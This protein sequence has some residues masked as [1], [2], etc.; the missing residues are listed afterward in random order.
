MKN[1]DDGE[2]TEGACGPSPALSLDIGAG[3]AAHL[4]IVMD[5]CGPNLQIAKKVMGFGLPITWSILPNQQYSKQIAQL[6][7]ESGVPFL[8]H[9]PMQAGVDPDGKAGAAGLYDI[10]VGMSDEAVAKA[11]SPLIDSLPGAYGI[12]NHR[13]SRA[14]EDEKTMN[15][16]MAELARREMFFL[17]SNTSPKTVAYETAKKKGLQTL[18]NGHFLDN[19]ADYERIAEEMETAIG[20]AKTRGSLVV[21]CHLR[22]ITAEFLEAISEQNLASRDVRLVTLPQMIDLQ[23]DT[24]R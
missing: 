13:G 21:I 15:A 8:V 16:V 10:G 23:A 11:L 17:D 5:D 19:E 7:R 14:T 6:L 22:P 4:A 9:V 2:H 1:G 24:G 12:N 20:I 18:K 3:D